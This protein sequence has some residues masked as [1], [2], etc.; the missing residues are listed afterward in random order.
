MIKVDKITAR[1][2]LRWWDTQMTIG[3]NTKNKGKRGEKMKIEKV[4][5]IKKE[6]LLTFFFWI[7]ILLILEN[8]SFASLNVVY[9][10]DQ[11]TTTMPST[12]G[13]LSIQGSYIVNQITRTVEATNSTSGEQVTVYQVNIT[14]VNMMSIAILLSPWIVYAYSVKRVKVVRKESVPKKVRPKR[15]EVKAENA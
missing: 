7:M 3:K 14:L 10:S 8:P 12:F 2:R 4:K 9:I 5:R 6:F 1:N 15:K 13:G 11:L